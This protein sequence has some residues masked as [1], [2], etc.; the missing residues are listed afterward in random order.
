MQAMNRREWIKLTA[1]AVSGL[2]L[3]S[4]TDRKLVPITSLEEDWPDYTEKWIA[5]ACM[6][7]EGGCGAL[8]R[9]VDG[10]VIKLEGNPLHPINRGRLCPLGQAAPQLLYNPDRIKTPMK[11]VGGKGA[12]KWVKLSWDEAIQTIAGNLAGLRQQGEPQSLVVFDGARCGLMRNLVQ[13]FCDAYGT[14]NHINTNQPDG[15]TLAHD[16]AQGLREPFA[17]EFEKTEYVLS[18]GCGLLDGWRSPVGVARAYGYLRQERPGAKAKIVQVER[19]FSTTAARADEWVPINPGT[20]GALALAIAYVL[21]REDLYDLEFVREYTFGFDDWKDEQGVTHMGFKTLVLR[22]YRP[23]DVSGVTGVAVDTIIRLAKEFAHSKPGVAIADA[24]A[25]SFSNGTYTA[26]SIHALNALKG[27]IDLPGGVLAEEPV[28]FKPLPEIKPDAVAERGVT[29]PRIDSGQDTTLGLLARPLEMAAANIVSTRPYPVRVAFF[30]NSNPLFS[31]VLES[32]FRQALEKVP[33]VVSFSSFLDETAQHADLILPDHSFL[34]KWQDSIAPPLSGTPA[35]GIA[36]PVIEPL[37]DTM[38]TGDFLLKLGA[39]IGGTVADA[40][41][42]S[43]FKELLKFSVEGI[44][45]AERGAVFSELSD[46]AYLREMQQRGWAT[47]EFSSYDEFWEQL[48]AKGGWS[49]LYHS[50]GRWGKVL[51]T[52]SH[53]FEFYSQRL[54]GELETRARLNGKSV[55]GVLEDLNV[56]SRGDRALLPHF[57]PIKTRVS[58]SDYP[59]F[60]NP[61][62][63]LALASATAA[64][65]PWIQ[66]TAGGHVGVKWDSWAEI[67]PGTAAELGIEDGESIWIESQRGRLKTKAKL[68]PGSMPNV[69]SVPS[70]LGHKALGRW[71]KDRGSN[72]NSIIDVD[73]DALSGLPVWFSTRVKIYKA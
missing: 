61:F 56:E 62:N 3:S 45:E 47:N 68:H 12:N 38:H 33:L 8:A 40:L 31:T 24:N 13:R 73:H 43:D 37:Y 39:A 51:N 27:N 41:A 70:G 63:S 5:S 64:N 11:R 67:N 9:V 32:R 34:E 16:L 21:I 50:Y 22:D 57:E 44:Y 17:Y 54:K 10:G 2:A 7:C 69:V 49:G 19:R 60:L 18:F 25:T 66:E 48:V 1:G 35:L 20:E 26:L 46:E 42:W 55:D 23:D 65:L 15:M 29:M 14:P 58:D 36:Q 59:F 28:P 6:Q 71:A 52:P 30:Y 72:P 53:K 4:C